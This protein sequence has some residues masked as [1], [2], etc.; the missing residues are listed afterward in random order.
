MRAIKRILAF[1]II[2][3]LCLGIIACDNKEI[4]SSSSSSSE[5]SS[6]SSSSSSS[7]ESSSSSSSSSDE[8]SSSSVEDPDVIDGWKSNASSEVIEKAEALLESKHRLTYNEDG[9]FRV[10]VLADLHMNVDADATEIQEVKDRIKLLVDRVDPNLCIF[11]G[12]NIIASD[13]TEK[14]RA[15]ITAIAGYLEEK[16]IPWCHVYGNHDHENSVGKVIQQ[17][18]YESFDYCISKTGPDLSGVG[19]YVHGVYKADGSLGA[20]IWCLDSGTYDNIKGGYD[21]IKDDQ[22]AWYKESSELFEEYNNG[23]AVKG[24]MAFHIPLIENETAHQNRDNTELVYEYSGGRNENMCPSKTDTE[25][26]ETIWDRGDIK[27]IVTGHDHINDYMYNYK[28]VKLTSSPN[29]SD[30]TYYSEKFQGARVFDLNAQA[31]DNVPTYVT[32]I[33]DRGGLDSDDYSAL[34]TDILLEDANNEI[35]DYTKSGWDAEN[36]SGNLTLSLGEGKGVGGSGALEVTRNST[37]NF[38]FTFRFDSIG[39]LGDNKYLIVWMDFTNVEFRKACIGLVANSGAKL[40]YRADDGDNLRK[41]FYYLA[42]GEDEWVQLSHGWDG[43]F[44]EAEGQSMLGKKGYFAFSIDS[45]Y[46]GSTVLDSDELITGFYFYG[47]I[48]SA[49]YADAPFYFDNVMLV[50]NYEEVVLPNE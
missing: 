25:L 30:L 21:Y 31:M 41:A 37:G 7:E 35:V 4:P 20:L 46:Q 36:L 1:L 8:S 39:T 17:Q 38:E 26:L 27:A 42:D 6:S 9:S 32:Y 33:I 12:D 22:I 50:E 10:L 29:I 16:E 43:C 5:E 14:A 40:P 34:D 19:N 2:A 18:I 13:T 49:T 15:N 45:L 44:G 3:S 23:E 47:D 11:T 28:G 24:I 48:K